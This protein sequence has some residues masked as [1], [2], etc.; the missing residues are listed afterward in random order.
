MQAKKDKYILVVIFFLFWSTTIYSQQ[1]IK[2]FVFGQ[3][4]NEPLAYASVIT[5]RGIGSVT[6]TSGQFSFW[7]PRQEKTKDSVNISAVGYLPIR[8][9]LKEL[10]AKK[11]VRLEEASNELENVLVIST[12]KGNPVK[13]GYYRGWN[14]KGTGGEIGQVIELPKKNL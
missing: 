6:D 14:E 9:S 12:L 13:F 4:G 5:I 3:Q 10:I 1:R 11:E 8:M 2:G 7:F